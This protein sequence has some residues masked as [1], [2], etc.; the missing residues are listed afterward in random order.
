[1]TI[2]IYY[3]DIKKHKKLLQHDIKMA[4]MTTIIR[5]I[6]NNIQSTNKSDKKAT[7]E[8]QLKAEKQKLSDYLDSVKIHINEDDSDFS[9]FDTSKEVYE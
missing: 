6:E 8:K 7:Y 5:N 9:V 4:E 3:N 2:R 1:M